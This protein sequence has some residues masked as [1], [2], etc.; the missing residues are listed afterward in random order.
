MPALEKST[1]DQTYLSVNSTMD[2]TLGHSAM[3]LASRLG[4]KYKRNIVAVG[5]LRPV[6]VIPTHSVRE[7][8]KVDRY[9]WLC[10]GE[11][12]GSKLLCSEVLFVMAGV[13]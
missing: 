6:G 10:H 8:A 9:G 7:D 12:A 13:I 11:L 4:R 5:P 3:E 1:A 2:F